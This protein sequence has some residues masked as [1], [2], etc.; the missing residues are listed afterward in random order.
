MEIEELRQE[1]LDEIYA[2]AFAG[3]YPA[4]LLDEEQV[5]NAD[6]EELLELAGQYGLV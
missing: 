5:L 3:G 4:M 6:K 1:L 2:G